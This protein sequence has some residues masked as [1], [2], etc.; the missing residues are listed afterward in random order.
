MHVSPGFQLM[1]QETNSLIEGSCKS[2]IRR[3]ECGEYVRKEIFL[4]ITQNQ[5]VN[6]LIPKIEMNSCEA[7][8]VKYVYD[9]YVFMP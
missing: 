6:K 4:N 8:Y 2:V 5:A 1:K 9:I 7:F 3:L